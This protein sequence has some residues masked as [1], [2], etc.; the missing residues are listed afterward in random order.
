MKKISLRELN[1]NGK[2]MFQCKKVA[3][4]LEGSR[5]PYP[6]SKGDPSFCY[7]HYYNE[8]YFVTWH[9]IS[10]RQREFHNLSDAYGMIQLFIQCVKY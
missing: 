3:Y 10:D 4:V 7:L 9:I 5:M 1:L 8:S 2:L 6:Y